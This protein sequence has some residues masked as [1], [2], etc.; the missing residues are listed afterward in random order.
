MVSGKI[1]DSA[2]TSSSD[3]NQ[4]SRAER[5]RLNKTRDGNLYGGWASKYADVG[6]WLQID[7][8]KIVKITRIATQGRSDANWWVRKYILSYSDGT[9]FKYYKN[10]EVGRI[11][12]KK[13]IKSD[14]LMLFINKMHTMFFFLFS[15]FIAI[16]HLELH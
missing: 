7:L 5:G 4:Y 12:K 8:G 13:N 6:Q 15:F 9:R 1:L 14:C 3:Y 16:F 2:L 11:Y 10:G